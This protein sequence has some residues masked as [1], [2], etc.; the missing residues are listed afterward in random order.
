M[1]KKSVEPEAEEEDLNVPAEKKMEILD[2]KSFEPDPSNMTLILYEEDHT[3]GNSIKHV[4]SRIQSY[5]LP[6]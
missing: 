5:S 4:L 2:P 6:Y 1:G 3:I